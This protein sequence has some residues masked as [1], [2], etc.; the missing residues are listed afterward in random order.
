MSSKSGKASSL[1][2]QTVR[3]KK[4]FRAPRNDVYHFFASVKKRMEWSAP[5]GD[6]IKYSR[7]EFRVGGV[8]VFRCG[9]P[10]ILEYQ[11][12]VQYHDIEKNRRIVYTETM[13]HGKRR[14]SSA[15]ITTEFLENEA[16]TQVVLTAQVTSFDGA[17]MAKAYRAGWSSVLKN[18]VQAL[19]D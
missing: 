17:D 7:S 16:G 4:M 15:L 8:D 2:H 18:L 1:K 6:S 13:S 3:M 14:L 11:G 10:K 9:T 12:L 19:K 5:K